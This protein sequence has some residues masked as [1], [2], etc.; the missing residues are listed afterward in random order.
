MFVLHAQAGGCEGLFEE[1]DVI[2]M[3]SDQEYG[4][5]QQY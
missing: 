1:N 5:Y 2:S 3:I 4:A